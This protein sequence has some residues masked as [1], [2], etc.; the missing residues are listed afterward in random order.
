MKNHNDQ[1]KN[2]KGA[3]GSLDALVGALRLLEFDHEPDG[4]PAVQMKDISELLDLVDTVRIIAFVQGAK[5]WEYCSTGGTMW[6][7]DQIKTEEEAR[8]R[9]QNK[10]LGIAARCICD[11]EFGSPKCPVH[12]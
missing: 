2:T 9:L 8:R 6:Q 12:G 5:W 4:W 3:S 1:E 11:P 7:R 10:T